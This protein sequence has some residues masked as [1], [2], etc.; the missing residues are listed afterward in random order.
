MGWRDKHRKKLNP[1]LKRILAQTRG[2]GF[3]KEA[4]R[5]DWGG[6]AGDLAK[7]GGSEARLGHEAGR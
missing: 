5:W 3:L 1:S 7:G 4:R 2:E 6:G